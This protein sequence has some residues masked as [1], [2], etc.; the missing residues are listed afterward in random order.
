METWAVETQGCHWSWLQKNKKKAL[1]HSSDTSPPQWITPCPSNA[2]SINWRM[3]EYVPR[4][5]PDELLE[6]IHGLADR[7]GFPSNEEK[8]KEY[9]IPFCPCPIWFRSCLQ[10]PC[11]KVNSSNFRDAG[12]MPH[13][14]HHLRQHECYGPNRLKDCKFYLPARTTVPTTTA[15]AAE[16]SHCQYCSAH[17]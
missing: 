2:G 1:I 9:T 13:A 16:V 4:E 11:P 14:H 7:C 8:G 6:C 15:P 5:T 17:M 12:I 10:T 3:S